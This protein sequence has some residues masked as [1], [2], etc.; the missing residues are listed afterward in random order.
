MSL[1]NKESSDKEFARTLFD[2][3]RGMSADTAGVTR[4][5]Y[6]E[7]E[8]R[9]LEYLEGFGR[10]LDLEIEHDAAGNVWMTLPGRDRTLPAFVAGS[11]ADSVPQGGNF[12]GLAGI[13]A[14][15]VAARRARL[16][17]WQPER[18]YRVLML[19]CEESSFFG[20]AYVGSLGMMGRL[21][22][23]DL[24]LKHRTTGATLAECIAS[25]GVDPKRLTTGEPVIDPK[26]IAAFLE[27]HIEQGPMLTSQKEARTGIVTGIR[28][29]IRH[30]EVKVHGETAHSGALNKEYRHDA[31]MAA[32]RLITR[33]D[34]RWDAHLAAGDDLVFTIGVIRTSATAAISVIPGLVSFTVDM[35]SLSAD[36]CRAFHEELLA[37][38]KALEAERGVRFEFD[39]PLL[40]APAHV[41]EE[42]AQKLEASAK[43]AGIPVMRLASGAGHDSATLSNCG[44]PVAMI[45][46][47]NQNGSHN[48]H[49]AM[50]LDDFMTGADLLWHTLQDFDQAA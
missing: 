2:H 19:R 13:V 24:A 6:G 38:A 17:G 31:V 21:K 41:N 43:R 34:D 28:G 50:E 14:A 23:S 27:L 35:R 30:K 7:M 10:E 26:K 5:G 1:I 36:T 22:E 25:C 39:A 45:F 46:V 44:I 3:I 49:E 18:D 47:A 33:M 9:T 37:E 20:K 8:T 29:N 15:L 40:T 11:H 48:P 12:D 16:S 42:L 32:A 4:Q